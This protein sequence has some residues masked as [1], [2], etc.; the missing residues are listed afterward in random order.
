MITDHTCPVCQKEYLRDGGY[1]TPETGLVEV[2]LT[3]E[4]ITIAKCLHGHRTVLAILDGGYA[5]LFERALQRLVT[6]NTRDAAIDAYTA[7]EIYLSHVPARARYHREGGASP[8]QLSQEMEAVSKYAE[9]SLGAA[10]AII[11][12]MTGAPPPRFD[13][14]RTTKL[15]N[16]AVHAGYYPT[17]PEAEALCV[18]VERT[19]SEVDKRFEAIP[20]VNQMTYWEAAIN[21]EIASLRER[22]GVRDL[23][24]VLAHFGTVLASNRAPNRSTGTLERTIRQY[25]EDAAEDFTSWRVW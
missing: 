1:I 3:I 10:L 4:P 15:R 23:P 21:E 9:R 19:V 6:G 14:D 5:L 13:A 17:E 12:V 25:R 18:E 16:R 20:C 8:R 24:T 7:L 11:S 22:L 2:R